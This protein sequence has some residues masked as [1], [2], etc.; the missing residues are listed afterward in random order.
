VL[1]AEQQAA[2]IAELRGAGVKVIRSGL[3]NDKQA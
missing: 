2:L 3:V 1:T